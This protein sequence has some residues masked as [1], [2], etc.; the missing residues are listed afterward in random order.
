MKD[1]LTAAAF[2]CFLAAVLL[3]NIAISDRPVSYE[4]RREL[5]QRP[6]LTLKFVFSGEADQKLES[7]VLDQFAFR[8]LYR[9]V[10]TV[11]DL[12]LLG[13]KDSNGLFFEEGHLFKPAY[14]QHA[15][16]AA[17]LGDKL[18]E[19]QQR[20]L[21][22]CRVFYA[23]IPDK[24]AYLQNRDEYLTSDYDTL[25][26]ALQERVSQLAGAMT[27]IPLK[28]ALELDSYY[29]TDLH[30]R[31]EALQPILRTLGEYLGFDGSA[32]LEEQYERKE[33]EPFYGAYYGQAALPVKPD[34]LVYLV[35]EDTEKI[36]VRN[37]DK[38][39]PQRGSLYDETQL[40]S[41]D[42][43]SVFFSGNSPL[44]TLENPGL[45]NGKELIVFRDSFGSSLAP[46]LAGS[47]QKITL[48]DLRFV[49]YEHIGQF[50]DFDSQDILFLYA[51]DVLSGSDMIRK[52]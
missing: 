40:G 44:I 32:P 18:A 30:W 10:K 36:L 26:S 21:E 13:R 50:V 8:S 48:I 45:N 3:V 12:K 20:Y 22:N 11:T 51:Q 2:C 23:V 27:Y 39:I 41:V 5:A 24:S 1:R 47:Y 19:I 43:Y 38:G 17:A 6:E 7:Y 34:R 15:E 37:Y 31:Q 9:R 49:G 29:R 14:P 16:K 35:N 46:L 52:N 25:V 28:P 33:Y 4:E 42:S